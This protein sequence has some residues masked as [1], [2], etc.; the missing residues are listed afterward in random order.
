MS[1][2]QQENLSKLGFRFGTN[3]PHAARTMM[4]EDL[5]VL[6]AAVPEAGLPHDYEKQIKELNILGK[7]T[8]KSRELACRHLMTLYGF[9]RDQA[10][11]R[12][13]RRLWRLDEQA[14]PVLALTVA[15]ARDPLL[16]CSMEFILSKQY[17]E[18]VSREELET[19]LTQKHPDRF[20]SAS[21]K[22]F[23]QNVNGTWTSAGYLS[24]HR[25]KTRAQPATTPANVAMCLFLAHLEGF[26]GQRL[27]SSRWVKLLQVSQNDLEAL[28]NA[29]F[30]RG[31]LVFLNSG[32]IQEVRFPDSLTNTEENIRQ[33]LVHEL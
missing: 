9:D 1:N 13:F 23:A 29:A 33:G 12:M 15:L 17:G 19:L 7:P 18:T 2:I 6:F 5:K 20:S 11:F 32:G 24:G 21:L 10:L 28:T 30:H 25:K 14:Q 31:Y 26:S 16:A 8:K 3:G 22:S 27:F 4:F